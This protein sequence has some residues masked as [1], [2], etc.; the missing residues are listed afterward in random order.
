MRKNFCLYSR[1]INDASKTIKNGAVL[2]S[3]KFELKIFNI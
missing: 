3:Q 1:I 2:K